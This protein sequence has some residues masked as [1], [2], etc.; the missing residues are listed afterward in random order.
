M[1]YQ[2]KYLQFFNQSLSVMFSLMLVVFVANTANAQDAQGYINVEEPPPI[3]DLIEKG[4][5]VD[6][7]AAFRENK[8]KLVFELESK[9]EVVPVS[10]RTVIKRNG[11]MIGR[12]T[13][14]PMPYFP[15]E[16]VMCPESFNFISLFYK[17]ANEKGMLP[18]G[19][20]Q[21]GLMVMSA[22]G[23]PLGKESHFEFTVR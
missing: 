10:F 1:L 20:Y 11:E 9:A 23:K 21:V 14:Q 4:S 17:A 16:M 6:L 8:G 3:I 7:L 2:M 5:V 15:G 12:H 18:A 13:R 19:R 22:S